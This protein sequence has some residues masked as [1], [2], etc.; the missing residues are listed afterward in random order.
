MKKISTLL[1]VF[2]LLIGLGAC[3]KECNEEIIPEPTSLKLN[4]TA[5]TLKVGETSQLTATVEPKDQTYTVT[6]A[7]DK[8]TIATV[9]QKGLITGIAKGTATITATVGKLSEKCVVTVIEESGGT[10]TTNEL[11]ILNFDPT[12]DDDKV[13]NDAEILNHEAQLGRKPQSITLTKGVS[14]PGFANTDLTIT[15]AIYGLRLKVTKENIIY[16]F[17]KE[18]L[19]NCP[20]TIAMLAEYGFTDLKDKELEDGTPIKEGIKN[21]DPIIS[22]QLYDYPISDLKSTLVITLSRQPQ[23]EVS[24]PIITTV[25]DFPSYTVFSTGDADKIKE[26]ESKLGFRKYKVG[27][28]NPDKR[29]LFFETPDDK[30]EETNISWVFYINTPGSGPKFINS[31]LNFIKDERDFKDSK[32]K[33]WLAANGFGKNVK[34]L[35]DAVVAYD[36]TGKIYCQIFIER[37]FSVALLQ[38]VEDSQTTS[39]SE[40]RRLAGEYYKLM[41]ATRPRSIKD[42]K[43]LHQ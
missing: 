28:S 38:I 11:P 19:A 23:L 3:N 30:M 22:V 33:E 24:H 37:E 35:S 7:S 8:E 41:N 13:L 21:D 6:F 5:V 25:E 43:L 2:L 26:F 17:S 15:G 14:F 27:E 34:V 10:V 16:A 29:N 40:V 1:S 18:S 32:L 36:D 39:A 4:Q 20:K 31:Q 42:F 9:D 12:Y